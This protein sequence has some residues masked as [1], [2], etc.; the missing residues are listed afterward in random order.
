[1]QEKS[2]ILA[3]SES[4]S[5]IFWDVYQEP[6]WAPGKV[7]KCCTAKCHKKKQDSLSKQ[8][9]LTGIKVG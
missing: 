3:N 4:K 2:N 9:S 5:K 6:R 7:W 1:M 8:F